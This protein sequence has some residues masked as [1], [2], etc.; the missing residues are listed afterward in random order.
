MAITGRT[1]ADAIH[2]AVKKQQATLNRY[3]AK[4]DTVI[5]LAIAAGV[6]TSGEGALIRAYIVAMQSA[7]AAIEKLSDYSGFHA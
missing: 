7:A 5:S 2:Q 6:L 4:M 1:G 3:A